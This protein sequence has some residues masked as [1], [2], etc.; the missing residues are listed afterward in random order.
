MASKKMDTSP[1]FAPVRS[2]GPT[3]QVSLAL[4]SSKKHTRSIAFTRWNISFRNLFG[5][6]LI[7]RYPAIPWSH[8]WNIQRHPPNNF[9][10]QVDKMDQAIDWDR[11]DSILMSHYTVGTSNEG[12]NAYPPL[13]LF[14][15]LL[16]Q[17]WFRVPSDPELE[18]MIYPVK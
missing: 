7:W 6:H 10:G 9:T 5:R 1:G 11:I 15:C 13:M 16:L 12:A 18:N 14:K 17:K 3:G 4:E 2:S 8:N